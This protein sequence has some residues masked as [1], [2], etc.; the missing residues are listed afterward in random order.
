MHEPDIAATHTVPALPA[1]EPARLEAVRGL[2]LLDTPPE[3]AFDAITRLAAQI[4]EV[5]I[6]L[7][8]LVDRDRQW[9]KSAFGPM[10]VK[11]T[12]REVSFCGHAVAS[13]R[14]LEV[15]DTLKDARFRNNPLVTGK[16]KIRFY[17][18]MPIG[19]G[20]GH[21]VGTLCVLDRQP[22]QL[23]DRQRAMLAQ[24]ATAVES[25]L[26]W[27]RRGLAAG[28][29]LGELLDRDSSEIFLLDPASLRVTYANRGAVD[30]SGYGAAELQRLRFG[31]RFPAL[32]AAAFERDLRAL[33]RGVRRSVDLEA[34]CVRK[35]GSTYIAR[36]SLHYHDG[37]GA[38][39][40]TALFEDVTEHKRVESELRTYVGG[41]TA[42]ISIQ[43]QLATGMSDLDSLM[44]LIVV[45]AKEIT[46]AKGAIIEMLEGDR[47]VRRAATDEA[48]TQIEVERGAER[49]FA[50]LALRTGRALRCDEAQAD[51]R[52][53]R[54][55]CAR[56]GI[57]SIVA[58]PFHRERRAAGVLKVFSGRPQAFTDQTVQLVQ[59]LASTLGGAMQRQMAEQAFVQVARG[60]TIETGSG[61]FAALVKELAGQVDAKLVLVGELNASKARVRIVA[62]N[63]RGEIREGSEY[64]VA[65]TPCEH[66]LQGESYHHPRG[67][68]AA[69]PADPVLAHSDAEAYVGL[70]L[71]ASDRSIIGFIAALFPAPLDAPDRVDSL[72]QIFAARAAG[73]LERQRADRQLREQTQLMLSVLDGIADGVT[74]ADRNGRILLHNP[75]ARRMLG[76]PAPEDMSVDRLSAHYGLYRADGVTPFPADELPIAQAVRGDSTDGVEL[77]VRN[78]GQPEGIVVAAHSRPLLGADGRSRGGVAVFRD[79]TQLKRSEDE[80]RTLNQELEARVHERTAQVEAAKRELEE[81]Y[82]ENELLNDLS[83]LLQSCTNVAE[84]GQVIANYGPQ[85]FPGVA[86]MLYLTDAGRRSFDSAATWGDPVHSEVVLTAEECWAL[87]RGQLHAVDARNAALVCRHVR[88]KEEAPLV[89]Y[90]CVPLMAQGDTVG[91]L[92]L[93]YPASAAQ[94]PDSARRLAT[95]LAEQLALALGN[96]QLRETLRNQSIRDP[97]TGLYNRRFLEESLGREMARAERKETPLAL[98]MID[99][100]HFKRFNDNF[101]HD[102]GDHVLQ[103]LGSLLGEFIRESDVACRYGGEEFVLLLPGASA[104]DAAARAKALLAEV[105]KIKLQFQ[106]Q[107]LGK[108][109][110]SIG[111]AVYPEHAQDPDGLFQA[112]DAALYEAKESGRDRL[113]MPG[114]KKPAA[115]KRRT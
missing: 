43:H 40:I 18:G 88:R 74:V 76:I 62:V 84:G 28:A 8:S 34:E 32:D 80:I 79:V 82:R 12:P 114:E 106:G 66:L 56:M 96:I 86:G 111:L 81:R 6:A 21:T 36:G 65:G 20:A 98:M 42:I 53:D 37:I 16:P 60:V 27:R 22:R 61:F 50:A 4:C 108:L 64:A 59:L 14:A 102:A 17:A 24:L 39:A 112:A 83:K 5:P 51:P 75:A 107:S 9:F 7:I 90:Q 25:M 23:D 103:Q 85:L 57:R 41:L 101:G 63:A 70:P 13:G 77:V 35:D 30:N 87:R 109:T 91:L 113:V 68:R 46:G 29:R 89:P 67:A 44:R 11:E 10:D 33:V 54:E 19:D 115:R 95:T 78:A 99:A 38:P 110:V 69:F 2:G 104:H 97:L 72:L 100:D 15:A 3:P 52:V 94:I 93:E 26:D 45:S 55:V 58:V 105:R 49:S 47:L 73:E 1:D 71:L 31:E 92:Y 48:L